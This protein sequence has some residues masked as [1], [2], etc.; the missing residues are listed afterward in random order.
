MQTSIFNDFNTNYLKSFGY[1]KYHS[2][3]HCILCVLPTSSGTDQ[4]QYDHVHLRIPVLCWIFKA[5]QK[6]CCIPR[7]T[8]SQRTMISSPATGLLV[9]DMDTNGFWFYNGTA[10]QD[11]SSG[12]TPDQI[13]DADSDT[14]MMVES[15]PDEDTIRFEVKGTE[16]AK[17]DGKT[18][19]IGAPGHSLF[20]GLGAGIHDDGDNEGY[21][22][23]IG[24]QSGLS[25]TSGL[26]NT[27]IGYKTGSASL[28]HGENTFVGSASGFRNTTGYSNTYLGTRTGLFN[29]TG[30]NNI[31]MGTN[32]GFTNDAGDSNIYI[33]NESG[34]SNLTGSDNVMLGISSGYH[35]LGSGNVFL[36]YQAGYE[37]TG[38][39]KLYI[40]NSNT[41]S[42]LIYGDFQTNL[43]RINGSLNI[44]NAY[45]LPLSDG[46]VG[47]L[48]RLDSMGNLSWHTPVDLVDDAD[49]DPTNELQSL[50]EVLQV[51]NNGS[52][53]NI[54][55][56][57]T[58]TSN[59]FFGD[60]S[61]LTGVAEDDLGDHTATSNIN[62]NDHF[63]YNSTANA[64]L[65][66][67]DTGA[68][69][70]QLNN[71]S[72]TIALELKYEDTPA[73]RLYQDGTGN[74]PAQTWDITGNESIFF[75][76]DVSHASKKAFKITPGSSD[77]RIVIYG[78]S[79]CIGGTTPTATLDVNGQIRM[80][81][82]AGA[83]Y[84]PL[85]DSSGIMSWV[86]PATQNYNDNLGNHI[87]TDTLHLNDHWITSGSG[88]YGM[89][90]DQ[91]GTEL[92]HTSNANVP[93]IMLQ[94]SN[95]PRLRMY[96]DGS[97]G[98]S[99]QTWEILAQDSSWMLNDVTA[100][101]QPVQVYTGG[102]TNSLVVRSG[103]VSVNTDNPSQTLDVNGQMRMRT[104]AAANSIPVSDANGV[105]TWTDAD[106]IV[107]SDN[108]GNHS[109]TQNIKLNGHDLSGDGDN[110]GIFV[111]SIGNVGIGT[112]APG[113]VLQ[114]NTGGIRFTNSEINNTANVSGTL[115]FDENYY[116]T[117]ESGGGHF[118]G[119]GGGLGIKNEDGWG[120][121]VST[122][123]MPWL[124]M[125]LN[126]LHI[127]GTSDPGTANLAI[128]GWSKIT[129]GVHV[130]GTTDPGDHN[131]IVNGL[132]TIAGGNPDQN[133]VLSANDANGNA[134]W[135]D[136]KTK[137]VQNYKSYALHDASDNWW[138]VVSTPPL[139][140]K[141]GDLIEV[142]GIS[143]GQMIG[144]SGVDNFTAQITATIT[145]GSVTDT[146]YYQYTP[147][148]A[149]AEHQ[150]PI[151]M[152]LVETFVAPCDGNMTFNYRIANDG[153][154][155]YTITEARIVAIKQ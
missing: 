61:G 106:S 81:T 123:N 45:T 25:N 55:N 58:I 147:P 121:L 33:G 27:F 20:I 90:L 155:S 140:V 75:V 111:N 35:T 26:D 118:N 71:S 73:L 133:A 84:I 23:F 83:G 31:F 59:V 115:I 4:Y 40:A 136:P 29:T 86:D 77:N 92:I 107:I 117:G 114:L 148:I 15:S 63:L 116:L 141:E 124:N 34:S 110:E 2:S 113:D 44:N 53:N 126:S 94:T 149:L 120:A 69:L 12:S 143:E 5:H 125:D 67:D 122:A 66:I 52:G 139:A 102:T 21:N 109:A 64:G 10:W 54:T 142:N 95:T 39:N 152:K 48:L 85:C 70:L 57:D 153:D 130:G 91:N 9:F 108:L 72:N 104:G 37:E 119:N 134:E 146:D 129:G 88:G 89:T 8:S 68:G 43:L 16:F 19:D 22:T 79:V 97:T 11:L 60:G 42:P 13:S 47:Q 30:I 132:V 144:G 62:L 96:Q 74:Y 103:N 127:G 65:K 1:E 7:M 101:N 87:V 41:T 150:N 28:T 135:I 112:N 49:A 24:Y 76:R 128:D 105:M 51:A 154:D 18:F 82:G 50:S 145:C 6:E 36:G 17:M 93:G 3:N 78:D 46:S 14:R 99:A 38:S 131:L 32:A 56:L 100:E 98:Y 138:T 137:L 151:P 80:R